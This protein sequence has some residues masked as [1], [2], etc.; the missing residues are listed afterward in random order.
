VGVAACGESLRQGPTRRGM[1]FF[2]LESEM[3]VQLAL[4]QDDH[5]KKTIVTVPIES[6]TVSRFNPRTTRTDE[7]IDRLAQRIIRN[8]FEITRALW[9]YQNGGGYEVFAGGTRLEASHRAN[10]SEIPIVLHEGLTDE[11][12]VRLADED[13]ENDEY[14]EEVN[15][16]DVWASYARLEDEEGWIQERIGE[17]K[18]VSQGLVSYRLNLHRL[19]DSIKSFI[20]QGMLS[21]AHLIQI[22]PLSIDLYFSDWF[23]TE[24]VQRE[25]VHKAAQDKSKNGSKSVRAVQA[26]VKQWKEFIAYAEKV[27]QSLPEEITLYEFSVDPPTSF[28]FNARKKFVLELSKVG[29]RSLPRVKAAEQVT[30]KLIADN[31]STY[32]KYISKQSTQAALKAQEVEKERRLLAKFVLGDCLEFLQTQ[33]IAPVRLLLT[34]PPYGKEYQS[35]RRWRTKAPEK[36]QGDGKNEAMD[37]LKQVIQASI[38][39]LAEN[40]HV[41][42]FCDWRREP[43]VRRILED[44]NLVIKG[45]LV[46][47]K[48][49]HGAGDVKGAFGPSHERILHAVKGAPRVTPRIRD[50]LEISR[51]R[52]TSHPAEKPTAL[53]KMLIESTTNENDL[54]IDPF[55]GCASTLVAAMGLGRDFWGAEV[56][57]QYHDE[58]AARLLKERK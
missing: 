15:D 49:E 53:L 57:E 56:S 6:L 27:Y 31:L 34:D 17:A 36:I 55:A 38:P 29:A 35:N 51:S 14:H 23:T 3:T 54:V 32:E 13:N 26:D 46:W 2:C 58:G 22:L 25:M 37:L 43:E 50:V 52:E 30:K 47:V 44:A 20:N 33:Q 5:I 42:V 24:Q 28:Q 48:E 39:H 4:F 9:A 41:L 19:S 7:E 18:R 45:S 40:A 11:E 21:E 1:V 8:G 16:A 10:L 12:I